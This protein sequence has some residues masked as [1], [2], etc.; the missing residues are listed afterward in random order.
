[1]VG[2]LVRVCSLR[3]DVWRLR[4]RPGWRGAGR[5]GRK[6]KYERVRSECTTLLEYN[7]KV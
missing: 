1:M 6:K 7:K 2:R 4:G 5:Y 3:R